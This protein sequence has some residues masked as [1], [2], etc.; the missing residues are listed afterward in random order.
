ML[1]VK[2]PYVRVCVCVCVWVEDRRFS[3]DDQ[4]IVGKGGAG[5]EGEVCVPVAALRAV[6]I[7]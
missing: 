2:R 1:T 3:D 6:F 5:T 4:C 7:N